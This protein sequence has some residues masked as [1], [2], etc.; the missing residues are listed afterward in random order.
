LEEGERKDIVKKGSIFGVMLFALLAFTAVSVSSASASELLVGGLTVEEAK[1]KETE[2]LIT[3]ELSLTDLT[4]LGNG[5]VACSGILHGLILEATDI[6]IESLLNLENVAIS[7]T[8]LSGTGLD[9]T[10][11]EL[12]TGLAEVWPDGLPWL[13]TVELS[14]TTFLYNLGEDGNGKIG[15]HITC[16][17]ILGGTTEDLCVRSL[18]T[19]VLENMTEGLLA[20]F[21][22][23]EQE[24]NKEEAECTLTK[25]E[26]GHVNGSG[27]VTSD[28]GSALS[29]S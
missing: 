26:T 18:V 24:T 13:V 14:G 2:I 6:D 9:C 21:S 15:Y 10:G 22:L 11:S 25:E 12:C 1:A 19:G 3:G 27:L 20:I 8:P 17:N 7:S 4:S 23:E 16:K 29:V 5:T 28:T